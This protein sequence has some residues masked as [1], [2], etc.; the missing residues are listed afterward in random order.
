MVVS[1]FFSDI[2]RYSLALWSIEF[3]I[4]KSMRFDNPSQSRQKDVDNPMESREDLRNRNVIRDTK[5]DEKPPE[6]AIKTDKLWHRMCAENWKECCT[7]LLL[8]RD[9]IACDLYLLVWVATYFSFRIFLDGLV[10]VYVCFFNKNVSHS[11]VTGSLWANNSKCTSKAKYKG[12]RIWAMDVIKFLFFYCLLHFSTFYR[13]RAVVFSLFRYGYLS[14]SS[15]SSFSYSFEFVR[16]KC[17]IH[18]NKTKV[19]IFKTV[20]PSTRLCPALANQNNHRQFAIVTTHRHT[21]CR[22]HSAQFFCAIR[23]VFNLIHSLLVCFVN[24]RVTIF[25]QQMA[26]PSCFV[27]LILFVLRHLL[28]TFL[29]HIISL[30]S[31]VFSHCCWINT[32]ETHSNK[33]HSWKD[34]LHKVKNDAMNFIR[35]LWSQWIIGFGIVNDTT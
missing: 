35:A 6:I 5:C 30:F 32:A 31:S 2:L 18:V 23:Y 1:P 24:F 9:G 20:Q 3:K 26:I 11:A 13:S 28:Y 33:T 21:T 22:T 29:L 12:E 34:M 14:R 17:K 7:R 15:L 10:G 16:T 19:F 4:Y 27:E 25:L 8:S